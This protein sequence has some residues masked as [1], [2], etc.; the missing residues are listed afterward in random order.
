MTTP[1]EYII[2]DVK[3][4]CDVA[5]ALP[6]RPARLDGKMAFVAPADE[7]KLLDED[8][9]YCGFTV[10]LDVYL[11]AP[12]TDQGMALEW[13]DTQ[14]TILMGRDPVDVESDR[15]FVTAVD[16][17][18]VFTTGDGS[19]FFATRCVYSRYTTGV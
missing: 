13:L 10:G 11:V 2:E 1:A 14:S 4:C 3:V 17:P 9:T 19:T 12:S 7:W 18:F 5:H 16:A 8:G 6:Y 15:V